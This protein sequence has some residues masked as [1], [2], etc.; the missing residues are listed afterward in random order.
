MP[1]LPWQARVFDTGQRRGTRTATVSGDENV[2][3]P[4]PW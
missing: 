1:Q 3:G 4:W 2:I